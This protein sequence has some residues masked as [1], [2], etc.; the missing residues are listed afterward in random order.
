M[1]RTFNR[2]FSFLFPL[3]WMGF[4][5]DGTPGGG[6]SKDRQ[7]TGDDPDADEEDGDN[8]DEPT[9]PNLQDLIKLP[10]FKQQLEEW[11]NTFVQATL[12][13]AE[14]IDAGQEVRIDGSTGRFT[15]ANATDAT[16]AKVWGTAVRSVIAGQPVTAVRQGVLAGFD[17]SGYDYDAEFWL[18]ATDGGISD[19]E[20]GEDEVV[21][22][23]VEG[24]PTGGTFTL[25][26]DEEETSAIAYNATPATVQEAL[27]A[28]STIG[29]GNARVT[30]TAG[31]SYT[32]TF[33]G[34]LDSRNVGA[35]TADG[36]SLTGDGDEDVSVAVSNAG[37]HSVKVGRVVPGT[38]ETLGSD[39]ARLLCVDHR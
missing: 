14:D 37:V 4:A 39:Y 27:E 26:Y 24:S 31:V 36:S 9:T 21:T 15:L 18:S 35:I 23:T 8:T 16:E 2:L 32:V 30:G 29:A 20:P 5:D 13:A 11:G 34:D 25:T 38:A 7:N 3:L 19:A 10:T 22:L 33:V 28:L 17:L 6:S 12:P 1:F